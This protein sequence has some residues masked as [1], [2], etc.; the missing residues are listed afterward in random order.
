MEVIILSNIKDIIKI[1]K[2]Y[3]GKNVRKLAEDFDI[4]LRS[5]ESYQS[6]FSIPLD[7][8][9]FLASAGNRYI[10]YYQQNKYSNYYIL[11]E[12][13]HYILKHN[14]DSNLEETQADCLACLILIKN[15]DLS[16]D[17]LT[18]SKDYSIPYEQVFK[19]YNYYYS[20]TQMGKKIRIKK[21]I[22][23]GFIIFIFVVGFICGKFLNFNK[24]YEENSLITNEITELTTNNLK[25]AAINNTNN[26]VYVTKTGSKY[27]KANCFHIKGRKTK[28]ITL[29]NAQKEGFTACKDCF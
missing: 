2:K 10:I 3:R 24:S 22:F 6:D 7:C 15:K 17:I 1:A 28:T 12:L 21:I 13:S 26:L 20:N 16:K 23:V 8:P 5:D 18:L 19:F 27:H 4:E 9:A 14:M 29:S 25:V 11:H